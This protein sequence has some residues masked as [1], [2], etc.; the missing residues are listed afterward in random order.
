[1]RHVDFSSKRRQWIRSQRRRCGGA[2]LV[3]VLVAFFVVITMLL[4]MTA[5]LIA[6][7]ITAR[8]STENNAAYN[9]ARQVIENIRL[10]EGGPLA[11]G[12]YT[13]AQVLALGTVPQLTN[14][15]NANVSMTLSRW[16]DPTTA[17]YRDPVK[18]VQVTVTWNT[19][20]SIQT[21]KS[22]TLSSLVTPNGLVQ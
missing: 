20:G 4:S 5:L 3:D 14:L 12:S 7:R 1:M 16:Q 8:L 18:L 2:L 15:T 22:R 13:N 21:T 6:S 11:T 19:L 9:A 10:Y 17:Q